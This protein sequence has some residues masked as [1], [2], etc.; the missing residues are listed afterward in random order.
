MFLFFIVPLQHSEIL[1]LLL[2]W[3]GNVFDEYNSF[4]SEASNLVPID[5]HIDNKFHYKI[6]LENYIF[7]G[8]SESV[9]VTYIRSSR[10]LLSINNNEFK[11]IR[12]L[13]L[14]IHLR[15]ESFACN[16]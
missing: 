10:F 5:I 3:S 11:T 8:I 1:S 12:T 4:V 14:D 16:L 2:A 13:R 15:N 6:N 9:K 7:Y